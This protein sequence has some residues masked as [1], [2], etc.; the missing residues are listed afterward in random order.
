[1]HGRAAALSFQTPGTSDKHRT[2]ADLAVVAEE[3]E[4]VIAEAEPQK[5]RGYFRC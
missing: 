3:L 1:V 4:R 2:A 5:R